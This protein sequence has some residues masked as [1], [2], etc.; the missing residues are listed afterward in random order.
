ML[1]EQRPRIGAVVF[2]SRRPDYLKIKPCFDCNPCCEFLRSYSSLRNSSTVTPASRTMPQQRDRFIR[3]AAP[4]GAVVEIDHTHGTAAVLGS[5]VVT[6][7]SS[8]RLQGFDSST[9]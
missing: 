1:K 7:S 9:N 3:R 4:N 6:C 5:S 8:A 2:K